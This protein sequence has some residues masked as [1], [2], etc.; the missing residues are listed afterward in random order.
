[1]ARKD[2]QHIISRSYLRNFS[3]EIDMYLMEKA[4]WD[5]KSKKKTKDRKKI[6]F[7]DIGK[8]KFDYG[9]IHSLAR[10]ERYLLPAV[11]KIV[12]V[13]ENKLPF[14]REIINN[15]SEEFLYQ[16]ENQSIIWEI[17]NC[18]LAR[19]LTLR[20]M[21][22]TFT[23]TREGSLVAKNGKKHAIIT[24]T[25]YGAEFLQTCLL[26]NDP[27]ILIP[28]LQKAMS[29]RIHSGDAND[30]F[31]RIYEDRGLNE[32]LLSDLREGKIHRKPVHTPI[33]NHVSPILVENRTDL[34]FITGDIC[35]PKTGF[36]PSY[37]TTS[38][39]YHYFPINP[40]LAVILLEESKVEKYFP[41]Q[42]TRKD[43]V[44]RWNRLVHD[45]SV[46]YLFA[47]EEEPLSVTINEP[48]SNLTELI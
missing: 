15:R 44:H 24:Y 32:Q 36:I 39:Q 30:T 7:Y 4:T 35:V 18:F 3:P 11:D 2:R 23:C 14:L 17:A 8:R 9:K 28:L 48:V 1:M 26:T 25:P 22:E 46:K 20:K 42:I 13:T 47:R 31:E 40:E 6:H 34:Q 10:I 29:I 5:T 21:A 37:L 38:I 27:E 45:C 41:R 33:P 43:Q 12:R 19:S 16:N